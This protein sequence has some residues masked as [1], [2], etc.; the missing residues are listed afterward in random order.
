MGILN[1][2]WFINISTGFITMLVGVLVS[3]L[4]VFL[5]KNSSKRKEENEY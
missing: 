3:K 5:T 1:N 2:A 4:V